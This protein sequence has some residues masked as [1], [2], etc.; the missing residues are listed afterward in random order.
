MAKTFDRKLLEQVAAEMNHVMGFDET[1]A[2]KTD[3]DDGTLLDTLVYEARGRGVLKD[4]IRADDFASDDDQKKLFTK[5]VHDFFVEAG[6][7]DDKTMSVVMAAPAARSRAEK[8]SPPAEKKAAE[9]PGAEA[10]AQA[11]MEAGE[12]EGGEFAP[13]AE[14]KPAAAR[15]TAAAKP[16]AEAKASAGKKEDTTMAAPKAGKK[17]AAKKTTVKKVKTTPANLDIYG[18]REGTARSQ[19]MAMLA[20]GKHTM[21]DVKVKIGDTFYGALKQVAKAGFKVSKA[22]DGKITITAKKK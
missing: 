17:K 18:F 8:P 7:W 4:A 19:A 6:V 13:P 10:G 14:K 12:G 21:A 15:K 2:I 11:E 22:D 3:G 20:T 5:P 9:Q 1:E 16:Q